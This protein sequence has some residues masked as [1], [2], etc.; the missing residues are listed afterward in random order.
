MNGGDQP[1]QRLPQGWMW[2]VVKDLMRSYQMRI[3]K[4]K[5]TKQIWEWR[6]DYRAINTSLLIEE[7]Y[8]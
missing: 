1:D 5:Q 8:F 6:D 3:D 4:V 7:C 2:T